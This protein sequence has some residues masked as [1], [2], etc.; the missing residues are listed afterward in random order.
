MRTAA[1][2]AEGREGREGEED[3]DSLIRKL[4]EYEEKVNPSFLAVDSLFYL[5]WGVLLML[6]C[7]FTYQVV[8]MY[9]QYPATYYI[10]K[11]IRRK[12]Y[13]TCKRIIRITTIFRF[14]IT[15]DGRNFVN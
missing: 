13:M 12:F 6:E 11:K 2:A 1:E 4:S 3:S 15:V 7:I 8:E 9:I 10:H 5:F 14:R